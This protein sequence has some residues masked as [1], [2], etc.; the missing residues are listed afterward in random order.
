MLQ[1]DERSNGLSVDLRI[2]QI[3]VIA[4]SETPSTGFQWALVSNGEPACTL[5][6]DEFEPGTE[7]IGQSGLHR[8]H[9]QATH[10]AAGVVELQY[11][12]PWEQSIAPSRVFSLVVRV[13][14]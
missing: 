2:G 3:V 7:Q 1:L 12:Q 5:V 6:S 8:W 9:F 4:L 11:R 14:P 13:H 10:G